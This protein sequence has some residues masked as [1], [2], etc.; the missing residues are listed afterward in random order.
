MRI[1]FVGGGMM[2][3]AMIGGILK[4][5]IAGKQDL[6]AGEP[7]ADRRAY[8]ASRYGIEARADNAGA[9]SGADLVVLSIKPQQLAD[10][11]AELKP[12][13]E[14]EQV[15]LSI[16]AGAKMETLTSGLG[17]QAVVRVMPNTPSQIGAGMSVWTA[18]PQ[19]QQSK[20]DVCRSILATLGEEVYVADEKFIDMS[21]ALSASGPAYVYLFIEAMIDAGVYMGMQRDMARKLVL[22]TVLGTTRMVKESGKHPAE[23]RDMVTSPGGTTA[24][25]LKVFEQNAFRGTIL[26]AIVA[27]YQKSR[28]LGGQK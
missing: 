2:A 14:K 28:A 19:V 5:G 1:A 11:M 22:Q 16:I 10:V 3:E 4:A 26:E 7:F 12:N 20:L 6:V 27:A 23:L 21:T 13:L 17:H 8:L 24:E 9:A 15:V 18:T 25:A